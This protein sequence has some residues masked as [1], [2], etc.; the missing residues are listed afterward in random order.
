MCDLTLLGQIYYYRWTNPNSSLPSI[1]VSEP[2]DHPSE[3]TP[4]LV[5]ENDA[6]AMHPHKR[7][8]VVKQLIKYAVAI[9]FVS[10]T[11]VAAWAIDEHIHG[12]QPRS[13]PEEIVEWR[14][15]LLGLASAILFRESSALRAQRSS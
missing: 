5:D 1:L 12:N 9:I 4:L 8:A 6:V 3:D 10:M 11:G 2:L 15:Q 7:Q 14:S 13:N